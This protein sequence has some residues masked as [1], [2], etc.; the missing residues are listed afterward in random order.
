MI[1]FQFCTQIT[2][3]LWAK[4][5]T[6]TL[7]FPGVPGPKYAGNGD[8][9]PLHCPLFR[10]Q[11]IHPIW[12]PSKKRRASSNS[13]LAQR[14]VYQTWHKQSIGLDNKLIEWTI[15]LNYFC[16]QE[17]FLTAPKNWNT[18]TTKIIVF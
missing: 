16:G 6:F 2:T 13:Q 1:V 5:I 4:T 10:E 12:P 3:K 17:L 14:Q 11:S 8:S 7:R 15:I 18:E 9:K